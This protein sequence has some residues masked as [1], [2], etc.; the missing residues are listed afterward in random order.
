M[1][2]RTFRDDATRTL[3]V[4]AEVETHLMVER[5]NY[6]KRVNMDI[7][8]LLQKRIG[9]LVNL[10]QDLVSGVEPVGQDE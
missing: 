5:K 3:D 4:L 10:T 6:E 1:Y 8:Y 9:T 7:F 2:K